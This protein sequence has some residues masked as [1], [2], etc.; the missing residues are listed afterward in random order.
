MRSTIERGLCVVPRNERSA[1]AAVAWAFMA[2]RG[3]SSPKSSWGGANDPPIF[4]LRI[5]ARLLR[6]RRRQK[7]SR[8]GNAE[9][10]DG[11]V[12]VGETLGLVSFP[13]IRDRHQRVRREP[14]D[15]LDVPVVLARKAIAGARAW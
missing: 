14:R 15:S 8:R 12:L 7:T 9:N 2:V 10:V 13:P 11:L 6:R 1:A 3:N 4:V 5:R